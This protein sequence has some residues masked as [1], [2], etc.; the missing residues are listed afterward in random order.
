[1]S[2]KKSKKS[3]WKRYDE[4]YEDDLFSNT[5][6]LH[7]QNIDASADEDSE[8]FETTSYLDDDYYSSYDY[9]FNKKFKSSKKVDFEKEWNKGF[10]GSWRGYEYYKPATLTYKFVQQMANTIAMNANVQVEIGNN[11]EVDIENKK[12]TYNPISLMYG[13]KGELLATLLHEVGKIS[14]SIPR[15]KLDSIFLKLYENPAYTALQI[16]EDMRIDM[17]MLKEYPSAGEVYESN[18]KVVERVAQEHLARGKFIREQIIEEARHLIEM[19]ERMIQQHKNSVGNSPDGE[20]LIKAYT[21]LMSVRNFGKRMSSYEEMV[22]HLNQFIEE[23]SKEA[24]LDEYVADMLRVS[25]GIES[26]E[27][28]PLCE[29]FTTP[30][31]PKVV[32]GVS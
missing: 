22:E 19:A 26:M 21:E 27:P 14:K 1:M 6:K 18:V 24:M 8:G 15:K 11:W 32:E 25:Y 23:Q 13:T 3:W 9:G 17:Q 29:E 20:E 12:L 7:Q 5:R 10:S 2:K 28:V 4:G 16:F 31:A 30:T